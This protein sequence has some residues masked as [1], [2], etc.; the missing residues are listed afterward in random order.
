M[1]EIEATINQ[2]DLAQLIHLLEIAQSPDN[3]KQI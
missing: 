2:Q 1:N 3:A